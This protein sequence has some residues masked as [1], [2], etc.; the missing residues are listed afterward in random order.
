MT[1]TV[2]LNDFVRR[3]TKE[4]P[5]SYFEGSEAVLIELVINALPN[6]KQ[7]SREGIYS[8]PVPPKGFYSGVVELEEGMDLVGK[9]EPRVEG[10]LPVKKIWA[11]RG[12]KLL[13]KRVDIIVY[14]K[15]VLAEKGE[16]STDADFEIISINAE[17]TDESSPLTPEALMRNHLGE[18]G[19]SDTKMTDAEFVAA[20]KM[21]RD[22]WR[23][24]ANLM[25]RPS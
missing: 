15:E 22:Y 8:I 17:F 14:S 12:E 10:E 21:S 2:A 23:S 20:L 13:A 18:P 9:F 19:G 16:N 11:T 4:S 3:Q 25:A 1:A 6:K 5:F 24:K 7:L